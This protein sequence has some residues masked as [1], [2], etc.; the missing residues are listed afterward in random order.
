MQHVRLEIEHRQPDPHRW[1]DLHER[2]P[3]VGCEQ[4]ESSEQHHERADGERERGEQTV[5]TA[6]AEDRLLD[7]GLVVVLDGPHERPD[8]RRKGSRRPLASSSRGSL[9]G[10]WRSGTLSPAPGVRLLRESVRRL[11][12]RLVAGMLNPNGGV[13]RSGSLQ[14]DLSRRACLQ[15]SEGLIASAIAGRWVH[16]VSGPW[17]KQNATGHMQIH[18][19]GIWIGH[20]RKY[21]SRLAGKGTRRKGPPSSRALG[22]SAGESQQSAGVGSVCG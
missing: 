16:F 4:P 9:R 11:I 8:P 18:V 20:R 17:W 6:Q 2:E 15:S 12:G 21:T 13:R 1:K 19:Q 10:C 7:P 22:T 3:P 5:R 14:F